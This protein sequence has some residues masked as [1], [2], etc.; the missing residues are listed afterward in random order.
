MA[1]NH[2]ILNPSADS[3]TSEVQKYKK[4]RKKIFLS[5]YW[6]LTSA[7]AAGYWLTL[8]VAAKTRHFRRNQE[9]K[10]QYLREKMRLSKFMSVERS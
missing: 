2:F 9:R 7:I 3:E 8:S 4:P 10:D 1:E 5:Q 6:S